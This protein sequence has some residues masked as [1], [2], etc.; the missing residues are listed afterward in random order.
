LILFVKLGLTCFLTNSEVETNKKANYQ[1]S[2][3]MWL[4]NNK[5]GFKIRA[6]RN[7]L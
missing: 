5:Y 6:W 4:E 7:M 2:R 3:W 1:C